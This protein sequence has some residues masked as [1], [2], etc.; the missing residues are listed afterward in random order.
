MTNG[1]VLPLI[2]EPPPAPP[3]VASPAP[4][5]FPNPLEVATI[6]T[7]QGLFED[8][9][10]VWVQ[11]RW[12]DSSALFQFSCAERVP[13]PGL[14]T[15]LQFKPGTIVNI[16]LGGQLAMQNGIIT[17]RQVSYDANSH[18]VQLSGRS[19]TW[20]AARSSVDIPPGSFDGQTFQQ[21]AEQVLARY[22]VGVQVVGTLNSRPYQYLQNEKG[23][24]VW[25]FLERIAR[26]RG[27]VLGSDYLGNV[28]LIG[29]HTNPIIATLTEGVNI[30]RCQCIISI[31]NLFGVYVASNSTPASDDINGTA[32]SEQE[33]SVGGS[34]PAASNILAPSVIPTRTLDELAEMANN[35]AIWSEGTFVQA[36]ITVQGWMVPGTTQLWEAGD[37]VF[38]YSPMAILNQPMKI[39]TVTFTQDRSGTKT[40]LDLV[41]P[42]LLRDKVQAAPNTLPAPGSATITPEGSSGT[43]GGTT[44][45]APAPE[46]IVKK[47]RPL[48]RR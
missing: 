20:I 19:A 25:N 39:Q 1:T 2:N 17:D 22:G 41:V 28:L 48:W 42:W 10:S 26:P 32:A 34:G 15:L 38:V 3:L 9:D 23:E 31:Q 6:I 29:D 21:V 35:E 8:W 14:W 12:A 27:I 43:S 47:I 4:A 16:T 18:G 40:T 37:D 45:P 5:G 44:P 11:H 7:S 24:T 36:S 33:A 30:L 46:K 13:I